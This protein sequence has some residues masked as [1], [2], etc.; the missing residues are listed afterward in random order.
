MTHACQEFFLTTGGDSATMGSMGVPFGKR[1]R[2]VRKAK[3]VTQKELAARLRH[4]DNSIVSR[5]ERRPDLPSP[6]TIQKLSKALSVDPS[7]Y[8]LGVASPYSTPP[9]AG[10]DTAASS[11]Q[12]AIMDADRRWLVDQMNALAQQAERNPQVA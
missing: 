1:L 12:E 2:S 7:E 8:R 3:G 6:E 10:T 11:V 9:D 5:W 4:S